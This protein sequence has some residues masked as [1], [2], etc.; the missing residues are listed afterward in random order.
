MPHPTPVQTVYGSVTVVSLTLLL[1]A[2]AP[3]NPG[4]ASLLIAAGALVA[5]TVVALLVGSRRRAVAPEP[6]PAT[7]PRPAPAPAR[8]AARDRVRV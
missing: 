3:E 1:L 8:A 5:G 6:E 4:V 7:P 2:L